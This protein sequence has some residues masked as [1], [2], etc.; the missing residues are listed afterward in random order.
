MNANIRGLSDADF[1]SAEDKEAVFHQ[2]AKK[3]WKGKIEGL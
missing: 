1:I 3:L 2:N